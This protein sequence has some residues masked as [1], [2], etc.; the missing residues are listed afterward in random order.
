MGASGCCH[1]FARWFN[2]VYLLGLGY[3]SLRYDCFQVCFFLIDGALRKKIGLQAITL[4]DLQ[5]LHTPSFPIFSSESRAWTPVSAPVRVPVS[6]LPLQTWLLSV[7]VYRTIAMKS[8][9]HGIP[10]VLYRHY[11]LRRGLWRCP[12]K[13]MHRYIWWAIAFYFAIIKLYP[14]FC[15]DAFGVDANV[16]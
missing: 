12:S 15:K 10:H 16:S 13:S 2:S 4:S 8:G 3:V 6:W 9:I 11:K 7:S 5:L 1:D 14:T